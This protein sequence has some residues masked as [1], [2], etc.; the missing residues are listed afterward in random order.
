MTEFHWVPADGKWTGKAKEVLSESR[1]YSMV[2][3]IG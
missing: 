3:M 2:S 1:S